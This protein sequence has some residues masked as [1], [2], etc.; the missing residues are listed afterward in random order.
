MK[1]EIFAWILWII[2]SIP[3]AR[4]CYECKIRLIFNSLSHAKIVFVGMS[5][6]RVNLAKVAHSNHSKI[7][8]KLFIFHKKLS[9]LQ[10]EKKSSHQFEFV[11][12]CMLVNEISVSWPQYTSLR[13]S[14]VSGPSP[15]DVFITFVKISTKIDKIPWVQT[16]A[17]K[18]YSN[19][20]SYAIT[21]EPFIMAILWLL[22][23]CIRSIKC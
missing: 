8:T 22:K 15:S 4:V 2:H 10:K 5:S 1:S 6:L 19:F 3:L 11:L 16:Q 17:S 14:G 18:S 9:I 21:I 20:Y 7:L 23:S 13:C 12:T